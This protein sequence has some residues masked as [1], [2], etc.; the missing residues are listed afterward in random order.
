VGGLSISRLDKR[1]RESQY[2]RCLSTETVKGLALTL[3]RIHDVHGSDGLTAGVFCVCDT[4]TNYIFKEDLEDT[5]SL[6]VNETGDWVFTLV[7]SLPP[8]AAVIFHK[9]SRHGLFQ[10]I[11]KSRDHPCYPRFYVQV[12]QSQRH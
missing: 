4:V 3:P 2:N 5:T 9:G 8:V 1:S 6:F 10:Q 12:Y 11:A 7:P